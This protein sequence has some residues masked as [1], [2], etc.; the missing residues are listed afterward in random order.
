M[1]TECVNPGF[2]QSQFEAP[3]ACRRETLK[4]ARERAGE[5]AL[6]RLDQLL[7]ML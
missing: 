6:N 5:L 1:E 4:A 7:A 2:G 3:T